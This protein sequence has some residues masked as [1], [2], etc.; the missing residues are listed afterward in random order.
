ML[1]LFLLFVFQLL[2]FLILPFVDIC[3]VPLR[4]RFDFPGFDWIHATVDPDLPNLVLRVEIAVAF[5]H[6]EIGQL[7]H[8]DRANTVGDAAQS[9][10]NGRQRRQGVR[11]GKPAV[12][13]RLQVLAEILLVTEPVSRE[14]NFQSLPPEKRRVF[15]SPVPDAELIER[16]DFPVV[17]IRHSWQLGKIERHDERNARG[18]HE[19]RPTPFLSAG[20][21]VEIQAE[22]AGH[23]RGAVDHQCAARLEDDGHFLIDDR[24]QRFKRWIEFRALAALRVLTKVRVILQVVLR[25][26]KR[27][28]DHGDDPHQ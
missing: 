19:I 24:R 7:A 25:V 18:P 26:K 5:D 9:S 1:Q 17:V 3:R 6:G 8:F 12:D 13:R 2:S 20:D 21:K 15:G 22:L 10:R 28:A 16:N 14:S 11:L 27:L 23:T 4:G